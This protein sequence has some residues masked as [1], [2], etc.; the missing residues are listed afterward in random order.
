LAIADARAVEAVDG[1]NRLMESAGR[2][3]RVSRL[4]KLV[5]SN[6]GMQEPSTIL[7]ADRAGAKRLLRDLLAYALCAMW[8]CLGGERLARAAPQG[9]TRKVAVS[10]EG[11]D[12][13][14]V[15]EA[16]ESGLGDGYEVSD[17]T[18]WSAAMP[19]E[20]QRAWRTPQKRAGFVEHA[21]AALKAA[22]FDDVVFVWV[23]PTRHQRRSADLLVINATQGAS[24]PL[25]L[26]SAADSGEIAGAVR[27]A[28]A[29]L[30]PAPVP[31]PPESVS[32]PMPP[33]PSAPTPVEGPRSRVADGAGPGAP[34]GEDRA[35]S[36][37]PGRPE[38][39]AGSEWFELSGGIEGGARHFN[40][41]QGLTTNLREYQLNGAPLF[42]LQG[43]VYPGANTALPVLR[44]LG[45]VA[46]YTQAFALQSASSDIGSTQ[47]H[48]S[49]YYAGGRVRLRTGHGFAPVLAITA[50]Y[51]SEAFE[52][53][54][55]DPSA[56]FPS[57]AYKFVRMSADVRVPL[58]R[59][60][61][62]CNAGYLDVLSAGDVA[63]RFPKASV[64]GV[65]AE[66][67]AGF[68]IVPGLETRLSGSYRRFFYSM[69]PTPGDSF[70]AGGALDQFFGVQASLA[71]LY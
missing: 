53:T 67:G 3:A 27:D 35:A 1:A 39:V 34:D 54:A 2:N 47:T 12:R 50:A 57:V 10:V 6:D 51:G 16:V 30:D 20:K 43:A 49:R 23:S 38:H 71:Y 9:A 69:N 44:D 26:T 37:H 63:S 4:R 33:T 61:L 45:V 17:S 70:V 55:Y 5:G 42:A 14:Q 59:M 32:L 25:H 29:K 11:S 41:T 62:F 56:N 21:Q 40:Y 65:Q 58:G 28:I 68:R 8:V 66:L 13:E 7:W 19:G 36:A 31:A 22:H 18:A 15:R 64:G 24:E 48:W 46:G 52:F 60:A